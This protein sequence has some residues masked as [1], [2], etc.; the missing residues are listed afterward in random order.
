LLIKQA[1]DMFALD[2]HSRKKSFAGRIINSKEDD[3]RVE[4]IGEI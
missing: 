4:T 3:V 2:V 1:F